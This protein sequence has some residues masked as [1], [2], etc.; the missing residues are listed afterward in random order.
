MLTVTPVVR[1]AAP[2]ARRSSP[3]ELTI[4]LLGL[5]HVGSA[6]ARLALDPP[7]ALPSRV[8]IVGALVRD[9]DRAR[10]TGDAVPLTRMGA[11]L[12]DSAPQVVIEVLGGLEPA[13]TLVLQALERRIPVVT[14]NKTLLAAHG[15]ELFAAAA[16][17]ATPLRYEAAVLAGV[18]F[19]GTFARRPVAAAL[20]NLSGIVNG[21][22]N[23]ILT[24]M[25]RGRSY[26]DAL[27][28]AQQRGYAEPDP[29]S[30][31]LGLD[32][33][34]K[35]AVL[36]RHFAKCSIAPAQIETAGISELCAA[37]LHHAGVLGG[38]IKPVVTARWSGGRLAAY[39][40]P[41]F[42]PASHALAR[43]DGV[44]NAIVLGGAPGGDLLFAGPGAG[45]IATA[46]TVLDD[47]FEAL[48]GSPHIGRP[49]TWT[50][51]TADAPVTGWFIRM[52]GHRLPGGADVADL[53]SAHGV[54]LHRVS[55]D[56]TRDGRVQRW[57]V[58]YPCRRARL[59]S[60]LA[61]LRAAAGC[62]TVC[63]RTLEEHAAC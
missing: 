3:D 31:V 9:V 41:A 43:I 34:Q 36:L 62:T 61:A 58:A 38:A 59:E 52:T 44:Q 21:T 25:R 8:R 27:A 20:T 53:L 13:R 23:F 11:A 26:A 10:P 35:L 22:T 19:L 37:D 47:V 28:D 14:A 16:A 51:S 46:T 56:E 17:T 48:S 55:D 24:E 45:P 7:A 50:P 2:V 32:A 60:G 4:A 15:D 54:W 57:L 5:G 39:S 12:L 63:I 33:T 1:T 6:V 42:I 49:Q 29:S 40:G 18:P 30:D